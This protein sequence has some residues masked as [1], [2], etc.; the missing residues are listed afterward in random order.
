MKQ[1]YLFERKDG[2]LL[3]LAGLWER[4]MDQ[5]NPVYSF[6]ILTTNPSEAVKPYHHRSPVMLRDENVS[7]WLNNVPNKDLLDL[8]DPSMIAVTKMNQAMNSPNYKTIFI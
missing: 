7:T 3:M 1:P 6:S 8:I 5:D 2:E 4:W